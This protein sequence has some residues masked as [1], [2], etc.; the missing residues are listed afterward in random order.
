MHACS[1]LWHQKLTHVWKRE[2]R[3][4]THTHKISLVHTTVTLSN[5]TYT[6]TLQLALWPQSLR[7]AR[8]LTGRLLQYRFEPFQFHERRH[9]GGGEHRQV[10][11]GET[12]H[13]RT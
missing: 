9:G 6:H 2:R 10:G 1:R 11:G 13:H 7:T 8:Q 3:K 5:Y 4:M 12:A